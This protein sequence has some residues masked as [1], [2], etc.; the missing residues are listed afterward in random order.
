[1]SLTGV[2][3]PSALLAVS[4]ALITNQCLSLVTVSDTGGS[5]GFAQVGCYADDG[6]SGILGD[7][8][9]AFLASHSLRLLSNDDDCPLVTPSPPLQMGY[10]LE[11]EPGNPIEVLDVSF[12]SMPRKQVQAFANGIRSLR[13]LRSLNLEGCNL[14]GTLMRLREKGV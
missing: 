2:T 8:A 13:N 9:S 6:L 1:M 7:L 11:Q 3:S 14:E 5:D 12:N 4:A 10:A